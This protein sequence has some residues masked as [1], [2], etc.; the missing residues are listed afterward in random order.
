[1]HEKGSSELGCQETAWVGVLHQQLQPTEQEE[2]VT[3]LGIESL[4]VDINVQK[5][6]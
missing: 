4:A 6:K 3:L 5:T 1:M 2:T